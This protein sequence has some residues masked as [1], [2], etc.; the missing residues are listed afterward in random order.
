MSDPIIPY[1]LIVVDGPSEVRQKSVDAEVSG[2]VH[3][4]VARIFGGSAAQSI[5]LIYWHH[6]SR[7]PLRG[8]HG[9]SLSGRAAQVVQAMKRSDFTVYGAI[10]LVDNDHKDEERRLEELCAG[11]EAAGLRDRAAI[12]VAREMIEAWL[13]ADPALVRLSLPAG[14]RCEDLWGDKHDPTS[15]YP[16][17]VLVRCVLDPGRL[18]YVDALSA[19]SPERA[20]AH[21]P[22]LDAFLGEVEALADRQYAR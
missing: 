13:L 18:S 3:S 16:K 20:R 8:S 2:V 5:Q 22:S 4:I 10:L 19:W 7:S 14:K 21:A 17:H 9:R 11:A 1:L 6:L 12:G 15:N